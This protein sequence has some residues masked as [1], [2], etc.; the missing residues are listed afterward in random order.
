MSTE[1]TIDFES[2][3]SPI[4]EEAPCGVALKDDPA[5][6]HL[7]YAVKDAREAARTA[8]RAMAQAAFA[9]EEE[10]AHLIGG[11]WSSWPKVRFETSRKTFG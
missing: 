4:S 11:P 9:D 7:Y 2:L 8:E 5:E 3:L 1:P 10:E 6:S